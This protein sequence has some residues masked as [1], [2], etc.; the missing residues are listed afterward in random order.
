MTKTFRFANLPTLSSFCLALFLLG[1]LTFAGCEDK[2]SMEK[3]G[4]SMDKAME[5]TKEKTKEGVAKVG[6]AAETAGD[7]I[8]EATK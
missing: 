6:E 3:A 8:K 7:K 1:F 2:G 4:A 5:K